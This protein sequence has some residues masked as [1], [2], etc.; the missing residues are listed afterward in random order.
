MLPSDKQLNFATAI[1]EKLKIELPPKAQ[2]D[3]KVCAAFISKH[4]AQFY[5]AIESA[6]HQAGLDNLAIP[7][8]KNT[9]RAP[10]HIATTGKQ[11]SPKDTFEQKVIKYWKD[12]L[13]RTAFDGYGNLETELQAVQS[14]TFDKIEYVLEHFFCKNIFDASSGRKTEFVRHLVMLLEPENAKT[15]NA[16]TIV[17]YVFPL[18]LKLHDAKISE[19]KKVPYTWVKATDDFPLFNHRIMGEEAEVEGL[20]LSNKESFGRKFTSIEKELFGGASLEQCLNFV[21]ECF[22]ALT[23]EEGGCQAWIKKYNESKNNVAR[24]RNKEVRFKL[25]DGCAVSGATKNIRSCFSDVSKVIKHANNDLLPLFKNIINKDNELTK[26]FTAHQEKQTWDNLSVYLGHMDSISSSKNRVCYPLNPSQRMSLSLFVKINN[27]NTLAVNGPPGTGKTSLLRAVIADEWIRPLISNEES[28]ECPI[29]IACA[30]TNQAVTNIISSFD[31]VPGPI[32]RDVNGERTDN[33]VCIESRWIPHLV[34]YGWYQPASVNKDNSTYQ[35]FQIITRRCPSSPWDFEFAAKD[36]G[37]VVNNISYIE[38]SYLSLAQEFFNESLEIAEVANLFRSK[39]KKIYKEMGLITDLLSSWISGFVSYAA[40]KEEGAKLKN[41]YEHIKATF[42]IKAYKQLITNYDKDIKN[43][44]NKL[45]SINQLNKEAHKEFKPSMFSRLLRKTRGYIKKREIKDSKYW[46]NKLDKLGIHPAENDVN[47]ND[48]I[49][50]IQHKSE[51]L[52]LHKNT[53]VQEKNASFSNYKEHVD[54]INKYELAQSELEQLQIKLKEKQDDIVY[55]LGDL[56]GRT[57]AGISERFIYAIDCTKS[58]LAFSWDDFHITLLQD[59]QDILDV[60]VRPRLFHLSARYWESRYIL[61]RKQILEDSHY[62]Q[63][64]IEKIRELAML[65]PVFVTTSYSAPK[66]MKCNDSNRQFDYLYDQ[67]DLLIVDEAGQGTPE[68]GACIFSF[69]KRAIV[70]GDTEQIKP[71]WNIEQTVDQLIQHNLKLLNDK[72]ALKQ[73]GLMMSAG[74]I[75]LM[76]Q[77]ATQLYDQNK[78]VPGVMLTNHYRCRKPIIQICNEM[79]YSGALKI[80]EA[81]TEP[82]KEWRAPLGFL[83]VPGESTKLTGGSRCNLAEAALIAKWL[84]EQESAILAHYN[85][86]NDQKGLADLVAILTPFKGQVPVLRKAIA[87]EFSEDFRDKNALANQLVVGTVHSLQGSERLI[88]IFSM[89]E[90][91]NPGEK[92]FYDEDSS[93]INVAISRAKE[94]FIIAVDQI[95]VNY[96]HNLNRQA[97]KKPSDYLFYHMMSKGKRLNSNE[98]MLIESPHKSDHLQNALN[99]GMKLEILATNGHLAQLDTSSS[100]DPITATEPKWT[101]IAENEA[102]VYE[103]VALLWPDLEVLYIATDPDAEGE[104]IAW[105]FIN[106][107]KQFLPLDNK[108]KN[109]PNIKRMRFHSLINDD[110]QEAYENASHGLDAGLIKGALIRSVLDQIISRHYPEK[111]G[112]GVKNNFHAGIGRVQL[113]I[114]DIAQN[115]LDHEDKYFIEVNLPNSG[116][117]Q[118]GSFILYDNAENKPMIFNDPILANKAAKKLE[119]MIDMNS[120]IT[121]NWQGTVQQLPEYP[122]INTAEFLK[123]A[124]TELELSPTE[125]MNILQ[126]LYEGQSPVKDD[127]ELEQFA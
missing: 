60:S 24:L 6:S 72:E 91:A 83:V 18:A 65:A 75:M 84:K 45:I 26:A 118:L 88:V 63:L 58:Y 127:I 2:K 81:A 16:N 37:R 87:K 23:D 3:V 21:D 36:F 71:V 116:L 61:Y 104:S 20:M 48:I 41:R 94:V 97:L 34:S 15:K 40:K 103:R 122:A 124:C 110:I 123:L 113:S 89:V 33:E 22:N 9:A 112:L 70:V 100:W 30:A 102:K 10:T 8:S 47:L 106:R 105:H 73:N 42:D 28:P 56:T 50:F 25:V 101:T 31:S 74:S 126:E 90:S 49:N 52:L 79:V 121:I 120:G 67:A 95:A 32:L 5:G 76:A 86:D 109:M 125:V 19:S 53:L 80:V 55:K 99:K 35:N 43:L 62:S 96:G 92:H 17:I 46:L 107:V 93:L 13:E 1:A 82:K 57:Q 29:I 27:G 115:H 64:A 38:Y 114:L 77:N 51:V 14:F 4:K 59:I 11:A 119:D 7:E 44:D 69:A 68:I 12:G 39:I 111:L 117:N 108:K 54:F 66:L 85:S 98:L 78:T